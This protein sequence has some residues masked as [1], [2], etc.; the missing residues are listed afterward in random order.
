MTTYVYAHICVYAYVSGYVLLF[1]K[2]FSYHAMNFTAN[3]VSPL[4]LVSIHYVLC[5]EDHANPFFDGSPM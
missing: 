2:M 3:T 4:S 5:C 1:Y